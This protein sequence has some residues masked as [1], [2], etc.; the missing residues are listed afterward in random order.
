MRVFVAL[1]LMGV[2]G[3]VAP[4]FLASGVLAPTI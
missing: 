1:S 2:G 4:L 3:V